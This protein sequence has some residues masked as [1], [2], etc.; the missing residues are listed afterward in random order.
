VSENASDTRSARLLAIF[1]VDAGDDPLT[2][3]DHR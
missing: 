1:V 3:P 2:A